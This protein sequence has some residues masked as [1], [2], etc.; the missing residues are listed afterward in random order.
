MEFRITPIIVDKQN[1]T[2]TLQKERFEYC[3]TQRFRH[4]GFKWSPEGRVTIQVRG[5]TKQSLYSTIK[6]LF[7]DSKRTWSPEYRKKTAEDIEDVFSIFNNGFDK[8]VDSKCPLYKYMYEHQKEGTRIMCYKQ[9]TLLSFEQGLGKSMSALMPSIILNTPVTLIIVPNSLKYNWREEMTETWQ[10]R[11]GHSVPLNQITILSAGNKSIYAEDERY[12]II[13]YDMVQKYYDLLITKNIGRI[14][15]DECHYIKNTDAKRTRAIK[16]LIYKLNQTRRCAVAFLSG[17]PAPNKIIDIFSYL[18]MSRHP[19]G[20]NYKNF[21][22]NFAFTR[23]T[24]YGLKVVEGKN[25]DELSFDLQNFM[26]RRLKSDCIDL[27]PKRYIKIDFENEK[28][29]AEYKLQYNQLVENIMK[30]GGKKSIDSLSCLNVLQIIT[31]KAKVEP[32]VELAEQI[33]SDVA[34]DKDGNERKK[35]VAIMCN[36]KEPLYML[37]NIFNE[38]CVLLDGSVDAEDRIPLVNEFR[39]N[40]D[41]QVFLGQTTASGVGL[42]LTECSDVIFLNFPYTRAEIEQ[43]A[44]RFH[45][46]GQSQSVNVYFS[47]L[48]G[49]IDEMIYKIVVKKYRDISK[50]IDNVVDNTDTINVGDEILDLFSEIKEQ[51]E[52]NSIA[53]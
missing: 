24:Q 39:R 51:I 20:S 43:A 42:N 37:K 26:I 30:S 9:Y 12:I 44:D 23:N 1:L 29:D 27:P 13:N 40:N 33:M 15:I 31:A 4:Y 28:Y 45:R 22:R 8:A 2:V 48:V 7:P 50:L 35:K 36:F 6:I 52:S 25:I 47:V 10:Q 5:T 53:V 46:I 21:M 49:K 18:E 38:R 41:V 11:F 34:Y 14:I 32:C 3:D 19:H 16:Q 17:T